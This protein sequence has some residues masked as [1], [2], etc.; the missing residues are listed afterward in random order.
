MIGG[1]AGRE[2]FGS[3]GSHGISEDLEARGRVLCLQD[4]DWD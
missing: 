3:S 4:V 1:W 2:A